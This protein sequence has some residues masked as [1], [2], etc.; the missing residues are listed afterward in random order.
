MIDMHKDG[1]YPTMAELQLAFPRHPPLSTTSMAYQ[2]HLRQSRYKKWKERYQNWKA[3][4]ER[5]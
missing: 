4:C 3:I 1:G 5:S 2:L